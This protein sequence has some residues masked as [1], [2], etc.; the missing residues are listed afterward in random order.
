VG[1]APLPQAPAPSEKKV[2]P[3]ASG[4]SPGNKKG[5]T[6]LVLGSVVGL[7]LLVVVG[8]TIRRALIPLEDSPL[9]SPCLSQKVSDLENL[10]APKQ[11]P[12]ADGTLA[13]R[14]DKGAIVM[15][16]KGVAGTGMA[17]KVSEIVA[18]VLPN[19][20]A[21]SMVRSLP[22]RQ[23]LKLDFRGQPDPVQRARLALKTYQDAEQLV[24]AYELLGGHRFARWSLSQGRLEVENRLGPDGP[25]IVLQLFPG[26][27]SPSAQADIDRG[28]AGPEVPWDGPLNQRTDA[29]YLVA[30]RKSMMAQGWWY[31]DAEAFMSAAASDGVERTSAAAVALTVLTEW[32][33]TSDQWDG[34]IRH[35]IWS[36]CFVPRMNVFASNS[37][38]QRFDELAGAKEIDPLANPPDY[39]NPDEEIAVEGRTFNASIGSTTHTY[40]AIAMGDPLIDRSEETSANRVIRRAP[41]GARDVA[42]RLIK[43]PK[44]LA[45]LG[46]EL[47][48]SRSQLLKPGP[49]EL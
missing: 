8:V 13:V 2:S 33:R 49:P 23:V 46:E 48:K 28:V 34:R 17:E 9:Y 32:L 6:K 42:V 14:L 45:A 7:V 47:V 4:P 12:C 44:F 26:D 25:E 19:L 20:P 43:S 30:L 38:R 15:V 3:A 22:I 1:F 37:P 31:D 40:C 10:A 27:G 41:Q 5:S 11:V 39:H 29:S 16:L 36:S 35:S 24:E 21:P 18:R